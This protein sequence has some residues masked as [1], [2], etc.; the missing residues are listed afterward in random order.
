MTRM[1]MAVMAAVAL[2][3]CGGQDA[4]VLALKADAAAGKTAYLAN[5]ARCHGPDG[6][7]NQSGPSLLERAK[8]ESKGELVLSVINGYEAKPPSTLSMPAFGKDLTNQQ[9]ADVVEYVKVTFG[10]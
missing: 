6:K 1:M 3:G 4:A 10:N 7:G 9:I 2:V 8:K 5:C